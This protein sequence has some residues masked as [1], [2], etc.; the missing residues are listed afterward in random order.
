MWIVKPANLNQGR[1]IEIFK[2]LKDIVSFLVNKSC[3][4]YWV[5]QKYIERPLLYQ[6][7]KFDIRIWVLM[8]NKCEVFFYNKGIKIKL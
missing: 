2:H 4:T 5:I 6:E 8:T 7:R 1:G 3:N